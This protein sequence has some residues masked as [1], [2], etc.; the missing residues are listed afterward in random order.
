MSSSAQFTPPPNTSKYFNKN[1]WHELKCDLFNVS[2]TQ[3]PIIIIGDMNARVGLLSDFQKS[4]KLNSS[5]QYNRL[6]KSSP[7]KKL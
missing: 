7:R 5:T 3:S 2:T 4:D 6:I 1:I